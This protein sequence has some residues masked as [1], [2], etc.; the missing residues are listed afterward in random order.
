MKQRDRTAV[1]VL[2]S[3]LAAI[4]NAEA[5]PLGDVPAHLAVGEHVA[6]VAVGVGASEIGRRHLTD[7]DLHAIVELEV[8]QRA[9]AAEEYERLGR[10]DLA[11]GLRAEADVLRSYLHAEK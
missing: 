5:P 1:S 4:D 6:G 3:A 10:S 11:D 8:T 9:T 2:R 7:E